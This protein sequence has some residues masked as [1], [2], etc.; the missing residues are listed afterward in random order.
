[1]WLRYDVDVLRHSLFIL[2]MLAA[3][4]TPSRAV[5]C[6]GPIPGPRTLLKHG[7]AVFVGTVIKRDEDSGQ[8]EFRVT[9]AFKGVTAEYV[10]VAEFPGELHYEVG[11]QY[12]VFAGPCPWEPRGSDCLTS[13]PCSSTTRPLKYAQA[14]VEQLRAEK[15]GR[16]VASLYG[17]LWRGLGASG[18]IGEEGYDRPMANV[19]VRVRVGKRSFETKTDEHGVY[20]FP[21]LPRGRYEVSADL[22]PGLA[23]AQ[24][25]GQDPVPPFDLPSRSSFEYDIYALPTGRI[26]GKVIGTDGQPL[27]TAEVDLYRLS[28][29]RERKSGLWSLQGEGKPG[30]KWKPFEFYHLPPDDYVLVFNSANRENPDAPFPRTFY[31]HSSDLEG[32]QVIYLADGQQILNADIHVGNP[33]PTRQITLRLLWDGK[34]PEKFYPPQVIVE[35]STGTQPHPFRSGQDTYTLSLLLGARYTIHADA[36]CQIGTTGRA[37]TGTVTVDG[38]DPSVS[39]VA[40]TF[41]KGGCMG[42]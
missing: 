3:G 11:E 31:P 1:M 20:A 17:M 21:R 23:I 30:E 25:F 22:P 9:E 6:S 35:A 41:D 10:N 2:G 32:S 8:S 27:R 26:S 12:L 15:N 19:A 24:Q 28:G 42:K 13:H 33:L 5:D 14:I 7:Q 4:L 29:Y 40:L 36:L 34:V 37:E 39:Q 18:G 38:S 16:R